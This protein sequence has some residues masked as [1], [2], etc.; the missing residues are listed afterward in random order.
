MTLHGYLFGKHFNS[1]LNDEAGIVSEQ[2]QPDVGENAMGW[3][4]RTTA[5]VG[6]ADN[7]QC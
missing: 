7:S 3:N 1:N 2:H 4:Q 5:T 6:F